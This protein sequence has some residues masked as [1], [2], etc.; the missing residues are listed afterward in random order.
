MYDNH[1]GKVSD[2]WLLYLEEY[3][4]QFLPYRDKAVNLLEIGIQNGG[5]LEIWAK[6]FGNGQNIVGCDVNAICAGLRYDDPRVQVV[7]G[8]INSDATE[9]TI[10]SYTD[11]YDIVIDDGSHMS[12]DIVQSFCRYFRLLKDGGIYVVEDLSCS[13][14]QKYDGGLYEPFSSISFFKRIVDS[15]NHEHWGIEKTRA[16]LIHGFG[17]RYGAAVDDELLGTVHSVEF[18]NSL[19]IVRKRD[20]V[21][22]YLRDRVVVGQTAMV[23]PEVAALSG[24][25]I[26]ENQCDNPY[27]CISG[28]IEE[29]YVKVSGELAEVKEQLQ[30]YRERVAGLEKTIDDQSGTIS[31]LYHKTETG[32]KQLATA[33]DELREK[34][35][36]LQGMIDSLSWQVTKPVRKLLKSIRKRTKKVRK[37]VF[38]NEETATGNE[39]SNPVKDEQDYAKWVELYGQLTSRDK[40]NIAGRI[41]LFS[42]KPL[43]SVLMPVYNTPEDYLEEAILSVINQLYPNWELCIAD[44]HSDDERARKIIRKYADRDSRIRYLF[45][46]ENGHIS[47]A[48]NSTLE[49]ATGDFVVLLDHDDVL[50]PDALYRVVKEIV[51]HPDVCIIYSD[52]DKLDLSGNRCDPYYKPAFNYNLLLCQNYL[53]H[54]IG[55]RTSE[56]RAVGGFREGYEG[57]QDY[58]LC[59]RVVER[60]GKRHI[61]HIPRV[62]YHWRIHKNSMANPGNAKPYAHLAARR[63]INEHLERMHIRA[64]AVDAPEAPGMSRV[65]YALPEIKPSVDIIIL[66]RDKAE[67]LKKCIDSIVQKTIYTNYRIVLV[68]NG[69]G[70]METHELFAVL[71]ESP[72]ISIIRVDEPFNFSRLNNYAVERSTAEYVCLLNNDIKIISRDWLD[73]MVG[74]AIQEG[75]GAVGARLWYPDDRL[76]H[77][78]V[79]LGIGGVA[80]H[81]FKNASKG[82]SSCFSRSCLQQEYSAVTGACL[83]VKRDHYIAVGGLDENNLAIAFNDIDFCLRLRA[84]GLRNVWT[85]YAEMYHLESASRGYEDTPDKQARFCAEVNYMKQRWAHELQ[86]DYSYNP[87]L[88]IEKED[89]ALAWPPRTSV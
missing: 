30:Q 31:S 16:E 63:A 42:R 41:A 14:W 56:V 71:R 61:R 39:G 7:V 6:Y 8:D 20:G 80:G 78:G 50:C 11:A 47:A 77:G 36:V 21:M 17:E 79:V 28:D 81:A 37:Y 24:F 64:E 68:D 87:N 66:T 75:V 58:D 33:L 54:L 88:S 62:L 38:R 43:I 5:S 1:Q 27:S 9:K 72:L 35:L 55:Y 76:Q 49:M 69:S 74:H 29:R 85:P 48:S 82:S 22:N 86:N 70:E 19:C 15:I 89:F 59:L 53:A 23:S 4:R 10:I 84:C 12:G 65:R 40:A 46:K 25:S 2:K 44:D 83:L 34:Q 73:E 67:M 3:D 32:E 18:F 57:S 26:P 13:Y 60:V 45:R 51:E 52:E